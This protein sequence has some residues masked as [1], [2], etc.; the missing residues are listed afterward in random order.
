[1]EIN[2]RVEPW[3]EERLQPHGNMISSSVAAIAAIAGGCDSLTIIPEDETN[4]TMVRIARNVNNI[5]REESHFGKVSDPIAGS[6]A[7]ES[8]VHQL[9]SEAWKDFQGS[10]SQWNKLQQ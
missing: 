5:L 10:I 1:M 7:I 8:M 6:Y 3:R 9:A 2:I 4:E